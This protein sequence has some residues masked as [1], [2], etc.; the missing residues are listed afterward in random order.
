MIA[1]NN[2]NV[3]TPKFINDIKYKYRILYNNEQ[4]K[5]HTKTKQKI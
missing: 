5:Q 1:Y 4:K 3:I 2:M